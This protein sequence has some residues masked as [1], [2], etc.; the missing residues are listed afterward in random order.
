MASNHSIEKPVQ[1]FL[2]L[3]LSNVIV[4]WQ[5]DT[6]GQRQSVVDIFAKHILRAAFAPLSRL[7]TSAQDF[8]CLPSGSIREIDNSSIER[9]GDR[10]KCIFD[11]RLSL[12]CPKKSSLTSIVRIL[13]LHVLGSFSLNL[14]PCIL[15]RPLPL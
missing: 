3:A 11:Q 10:R 1:E 2:I 14:S 8:L 13:S 15:G 4:V 12:T 6:N 7:T 5:S 9:S